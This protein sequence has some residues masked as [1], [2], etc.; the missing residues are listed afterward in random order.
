MSV[1]PNVRT[2]DPKKVI[3]TFG[4]VIMTGFASGTFVSIEP[5][6][7]A[8]EMNQGADGT[9]DRT[10]KNMN[11]YM[12]TVTLKQ[13]SISNNPLSLIHIADKLSNTGKFPLTV[14]DL[15]GSSKFFAPIA[16][17]EGDPTGE[18]GDTS[19]SREWK[20]Q[21]GIAANVIGGNLT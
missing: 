17:I 7:P 21:T 5:G 4:T 9:I 19:G 11:H 15:N 18:D 8:F 14:N 13:T 12:V 6:G 3:V 16:W 2:Y 1:D 10:N 20:F